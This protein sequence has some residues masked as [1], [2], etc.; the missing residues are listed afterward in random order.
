MTELFQKDTVP[1]RS[2]SDLF[3]Q[4]TEAEMLS[5]IGT[6]STTISKFAA[7]ITIERPHI[8]G[9]I[10][11]GMTFKSASS[12]ARVEMFPA[13]DS[14]IGFV[15]YDDVGA[16]VLKMLVSGSDVG[17]LIIGNYAGGNGLKWDKSSGVFTVKGIL[18]VSAIAI[19]DGVTANSFHVNATGDAWW[20]ATTIGSATAKILNTGVATFSNITI[21][22]GSIGSV[23]LTGIQAGSE[24]AIQGWQHDMVFSV[25]D[26]DTV[27]WASGTITLLDGTTYSIAAGNTGNMSA[28]TYIYFTIADDD[29]LLITTTAAT[30]VGSGKILVASAINSTN[31]ALFFVFGGIG[32]IKIP[33]TDLE[34]LT[35]TASQIASNAIEEAKVASDAIT[36][37]KINVSGLDG[38]SGDVAVNHIV[39]GMIQTNAITSIKINADAVTATKIDVVGLDGATGRIVVADQTDADEV[40]A[41][42]N[43]HA[44]TLIEAG[45]IVISGATK[46]DDWRKSGDLTKIDG[47][48]ISTST[49]TATQIAAGTITANEI[50]ANTI[51][52]NEIVA[53]TITATELN[54]STLSAISANIGTIT[55]GTI[56]TD[57]L[58]VGT[59]VITAEKRFNSLWNRYMF[60]GDYNDGLTPT[61]G[62]VTRFLVLTRLVST[63]LDCTLSSIRTHVGSGNTIF[64]TGNGNFEAIMSVQLDEVVSQDVIW[65]IADNGN[66]TLPVD[67]A[68]VTHHFAFIVED[69]TLYASTGN[70]TNQTKTE[71][72]GITLT[73][74]NV[75][76]IDFAFSTGATLFYVND[77][78]KATI[79]TTISG[80]TDPSFLFGI[81]AIA[82]TKTMD[83]INNYMIIHE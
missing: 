30:A 77:V 60:I 34:N 4:L 52:A 49:I 73:D 68:L 42:I 67:A 72:T 22:G 2:V 23:I 10:A 41:G 83:I 7:G 46:L 54:I 26:A 24:I 1:V 36:A 18:E 3:G 14:T 21:T 50:S 9:G 65:G 28:R 58:I 29:A 43:T 75:Y 39:A 13:T 51:T 55:S 15:A 81:D 40:A 38:A 19:P 82:D 33:A 80:T 69:G 48:S 64:T 12:G 62:T 35:I 66:R 45:K 37:T 16:E 47:G 63:G 53:N 61:G 78:L 57:T 32:G 11:E 5:P 31:E 79:D 76:R 17:D 56:T 27:A 25:T 74:M 70:G 8:I 20:G 71:I 59:D 44:V 6:G